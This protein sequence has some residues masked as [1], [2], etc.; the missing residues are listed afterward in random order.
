MLTILQTLQCSNGLAYLHGLAPPVI[1]GDLKPQNVLM[2]DITEV[3][4][5]D[6][7]L[8]MVDGKP[9]QDLETTGIRGGT[10]GY[11]ALELVSGGAVTLQTDI[12]AFGGLIIAVSLVLN[13]PRACLVRNNDVF[14]M[15]P[16]QANTHTTSKPRQ[17]SL[18]P[19]KRVYRPSPWII[20]TS[21][22]TTLFGIQ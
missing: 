18:C 15:R 14:V 7:G 3:C 9:Y 16:C 10:K 12:F 13:F 4:L 8:A 1:H 11:D 6:F 21:L 22:P 2:N 19:C 5:C 17:D 20:R